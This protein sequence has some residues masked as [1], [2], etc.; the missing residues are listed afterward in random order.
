[1]T[2]LLLFVAF[3]L[4]FTIGKLAKS[5]VDAAKADAWRIEKANMLLLTIHTQADEIRHQEMALVDLLAKKV[6]FE[7]ESE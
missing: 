5:D 2:I 1:M 6:N 3:F 4:G 7:M